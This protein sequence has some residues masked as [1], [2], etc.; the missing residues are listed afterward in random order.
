MKFM[1]YKTTYSV[2]FLNLGFRIGIYAFNEENES[3]FTNCLL[4]NKIDFKN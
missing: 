4:V 3:D 2:F 1:R